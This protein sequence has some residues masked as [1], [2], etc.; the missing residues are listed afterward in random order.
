M[1]IVVKGLTYT[2]S[3]G[4]PYE[5]VALDGVDLEVRQGE[6]LGIIGHTGSGKSTLIQH[7]NGLI[8]VEQGALTVAGID[9]TQKKPDFRALR[10]KVGLVFQYP[11]YQLFAETV[12]EDVAFGPKNLGVPEEEIDERVRVALEQVGLNYAE[13]AEKSP[14]DL[15]G[16]QK[17]RVALAGVI[18]MR[19]EI[20]VLDEPTAGL[21]PLGKH[22][23]LE[24]V[25]SLQKTCSPTVVMI[26]HNLDEIADIADR[27]AV[28]KDGK[29]LDCL[30]PVELF[31]REDLVA[32]T[33][34]VPTSVKI[35]RMLRERGVEV[36]TPVRKSV[37]ASLVLDKYGAKEGKD[38]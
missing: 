6:F 11:E 17:R 31:D 25:K 2:Y 15:S 9:L 37:L 27:I 4:T 14:F 18:A 10:R 1:S 19:P 8:R 5:K 30:A 35:A 20:L 13:I 7:F 3:K 36:G 32:V 38:A 16:G 29:V 26:S 34:A 12:R 33:G 28:M 22:D 23:I 24:L 21:D